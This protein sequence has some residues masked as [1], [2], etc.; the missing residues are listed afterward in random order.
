M[1]RLSSNWTFFNKRIFP[2]IWFGSLGVFTL[3]LSAVLILG[4]QDS[5]P[6]NI[7]AFFAAPVVM[8]VFGFVVL[9]WQVWRLVDRVLDCGSYLLVQ[10]GD[11]EEKVHLNNIINV[12]VSD[13]TAPQRITLLLKNES[14]L[15]T[16]ISFCPPV[17]FNPFARCVVADD[18][19]A[20]TV[21]ARE[22][23]TSQ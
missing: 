4:P 17:Q 7:A 18:L 9:K 1:R 3:I 16:E 15:G 12:S 5:L 13:F 23:Q 14:K 20:R 10:N 22:Q 6:P 2:V 21:K 19:I 11:I 8:G